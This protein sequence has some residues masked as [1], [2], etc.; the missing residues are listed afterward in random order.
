MKLINATKGNT[1]AKNVI[2]VDDP[3]E[4]SRGLIPYKAGNNCLYDCFKKKDFGKGDAMV[5]KVNS[6]GTVHTFF[7]S[8]PISVFFLNGEFK[9][10]E[11]TFLRPFRMYFP[12]INYKYFVEIFGYK[13]HK[14]DVGDVFRLKK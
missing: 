13:L 14:I 9:V 11:K 6:R 2:P 7:M 3:D 8:F 1:I 4:I 12:K 10:I 5:F